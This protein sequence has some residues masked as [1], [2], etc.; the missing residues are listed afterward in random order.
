[1]AQ[2][3][4]NPEQ[5]L[6]KHVLSQINSVN[7]DENCVRNL[8]TNNLPNIKHLPYRKT[9]LENICQ[10]PDSP[11]DVLWKII[12]NEI[13]SLDQSKNL[14]YTLSIINRDDFL[15]KFSDKQF[16]NNLVSQLSGLVSG[17]L[18]VAKNIKEK[19]DPDE[20]EKLSIVWYLIQHP[21]LSQDVMTRIWNEK[22]KPNLRYLSSNFDQGDIVSYLNPMLK[23][24]N[25]PTQ[26]I[27]E[28]VEISLR[29]NPFGNFTKDVVQ[30]VLN[31][32]RAS[33]KTIKTISL[34]KP[35][36]DMSFVMDQLVCMPNAPEEESTKWIVDS[37]ERGL[38]F[39][40]SKISNPAVKNSVQSEL[41]EK[42]LHRNIHS[43]DIPSIED[44]AKNN[45]WYKLSQKFQYDDRLKEVK[46]TRLQEEIANKNYESEKK[47]A[48]QY[49]RL[50][51]SA[52]LSGDINL[53]FDMAK[54]ICGDQKSSFKNSYKGS[55]GRKLFLITIIV[56]IE[57]DGMRKVFEF[58]WDYFLG[59]QIKSQSTDTEFL[60]GAGVLEKL[61]ENSQCPDNIFNDVSYMLLNNREKIPTFVQKEIGI[62]NTILEHQD[63]PA[64]TL[65]NLYK[66]KNV[67]NNEFFRDQIVTKANAPIDVI[68]NV[69]AQNKSKINVVKNIK[70][71]DVIVKDYLHSVEDLDSDLIRKLV[72]STSTSTET[73]AII[74]DYMGT[75]NFFSTQLSLHPNVPTEWAVEYFLNNIGKFKKY[76]DLIKNQDV[77]Q[78]VA[79]Q[80][81]DKVIFDISPEEINRRLELMEESFQKNTIIKTAD[82]NSK[83]LDIMKLIDNESLSQ[84]RLTKIW[85]TFLDIH[86]DFVKYF[87]PNNI[88]AIQDRIAIH[89]N[90]PDKVINYLINDC[91][92]GGNLVSNIR[93]QKI[94]MGILKYYEDIAGYRT[95]PK[96]T[97]HSIILNPLAPTEALLIFTKLRDVYS[98]V[99]NNANM[100]NFEKEAV[101]KS[102]SEIEREIALHRNAPK[103]WTIEYFLRNHESF[104]KWK[105]AIK[106]PEIQKSAPEIKELIMDKIFEDKFKEV[107]IDD[108]IDDIIEKIEQQ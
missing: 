76:K 79:E 23:N 34:S 27:D 62:I 69:V 72:E 47:E 3:Q 43:I 80:S 18:S 92:K 44:E 36:S 105:E 51:E 24:P 11:G 86:S 28:W 20:Q 38:P 9:L 21:T 74:I 19:L 103:Q 29:E 83:Y 10:H 31:N 54:G 5:D 6:F 2:P 99:L 35:Y 97:I 4:K 39:D 55:V 7:C 78:I 70:A 68:I 50:E 60:F 84:E 13:D 48:E 15:S 90:A 14:H 16:L 57:K 71:V 12:K 1:M 61:L 66:I 100:N 41:F 93:N 53:I 52:V 73:L 65:Q 88:K 77:R 46:R 8:F 32:P 87:S 96:N 26:I 94:I 49:R 101:E 45:S 64:I 75:N 107:N 91:Q 56:Q 82:I 67:H 108:I 89:K 85:D 98:D 106:N 25:C 59:P 42:K 104:D 58:L 22:I 17:E 95:L 40:Q 81:F 37:I 102:I 30:K 33:E 63:L